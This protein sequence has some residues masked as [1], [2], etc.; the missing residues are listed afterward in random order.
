MPYVAAT[1]LTPTLS[2]Y[3]W[4]RVF[5]IGNFVAMAAA[6]IITAK[7]Y[8]SIWCTFAAFLSLIIV[9]HYVEQKRQGA[10][11]PNEGTL[12]AGA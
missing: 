7:D 2:S 12:L 3:R 6:A 1:C 5:G 11:P 8:S 10:V 4:V 9:A